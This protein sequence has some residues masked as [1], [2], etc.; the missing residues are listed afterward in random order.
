M[1]LKIHS[2]A[3]CVKGLELAA[4][5]SPVSLKILRDYC[6]MISTLIDTVKGD[7]RRTFFLSKQVIL[8][9]F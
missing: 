4:N 9:N 3:S 1:G 7:A 6:D 2:V 5:Y 8:L